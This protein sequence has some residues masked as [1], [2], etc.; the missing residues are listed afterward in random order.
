MYSKHRE[1]ALSLAR[2]LIGGVPG[3][4][5]YENEQVNALEVECRVRVHGVQSRPELNSQL[6]KIVTIDTRR[7]RCGVRIGVPPC[8]EDISLKMTCLTR[9]ARVRSCEGE[10]APESRSE[11]E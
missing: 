7:G 2:L 3:E 5:P 10:E 9:E 11:P 8:F 6:G 1:P 4:D